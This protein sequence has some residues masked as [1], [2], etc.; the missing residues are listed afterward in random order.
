MTTVSSSVPRRRRA[1][2][3]RATQRS[4]PMSIYSARGL[5][6]AAFAGKHVD[7]STAISRHARSRRHRRG[8]GLDGFSSG[9]AISALSTAV[10]VRN[11]YKMLKGV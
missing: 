5:L 10:L 2:G 11:A 1:R 6:V 7:R 3:G 4:A 8:K 9:A